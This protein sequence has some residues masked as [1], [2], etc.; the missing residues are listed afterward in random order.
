MTRRTRYF[1][2]GSGLALTI[3]LAIGLVAYYVGL[4]ATTTLFRRGGPEELRYVPGDVS[5]LAFVNVRDVLK[6]E[7]RQPIRSLAPGSMS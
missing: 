5:V 1:L 3:G 7:L 4:P 6:S 2:V